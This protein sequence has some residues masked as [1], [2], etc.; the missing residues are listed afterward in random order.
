MVWLCKQ[1]A[2][3]KISEINFT[4]QI[5]KHQLD[6]LKLDESITLSILDVV[7]WDSLKQTNGDDGRL[8]V[9]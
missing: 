1:T 5:R 8:M 9:A 2:L 7:A 3:G 6:D 4:K